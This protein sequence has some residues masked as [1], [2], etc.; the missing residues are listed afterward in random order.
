MTAPRT[1]AWA[2]AAVALLA[3]PP[4]AHA[5]FTTTSYGAVGVV[6]TGDAS[7]DALVLSAS[8]GMLRHD[9]AGDGGFASALDFDSTNVGDQP[10][11]ATAAVTIRGGAGDDRIVLRQGASVTATGDEGEDRVEVESGGPEADQLT[12]SPG[13][14]DGHVTVARSNAPTF[15]YDIAAERVSLRPGPG[16]DVVTG[17]AGLAGRTR[18]D[19]DGG[20]GDD[21]VTGGDGDDLLFGGAGGDTVAGGAGSDL[22]DGGSG[23]D[24]LLARDGAADLVACGG[25]VDAAQ[26]DEPR[27]DAASGC[28]A[29]D[30]AAGPASPAADTRATPATVR[31][32]RVTVRRGVPRARLAVACP[33]SERGGCAGRIT[34]TTAKPVRGGRVRAP[35]VLGSARFRLSAGART[36]LRV[37]LP[38][39]ASRLADRR[40]RIAVRA[41]TETRDAAGNLALSAPRLTLRFPR[42]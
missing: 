36:K 1:L 37:R 8:G 9:Q 42:R 18:L 2:I 13:A 31:A 28:E 32:R 15:A 14:A 29:I 27:V 16:N 33:V 39:G 40:R 17:T 7:A 19:V 5:D 21:T 34:L 30:A 3:A 35:V 20:A 22:L 26:V 12:V 6:L 4:A 41:R 25:D 23:G 11:A 10:L 38:R 24:R